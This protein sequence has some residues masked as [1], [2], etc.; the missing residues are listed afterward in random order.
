MLEGR[1]Y[2][3]LNK[4]RIH[5]DHNVHR[6]IT[7]AVLLSSIYDSSIGNGFGNQRNYSVLFGD[8]IYDDSASG[9]VL[10]LA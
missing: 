5:F 6:S 9:D 10:K 7:M 2:L 1:T 3:Y 8:I 4:F